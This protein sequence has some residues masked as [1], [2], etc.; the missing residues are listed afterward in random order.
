[1]PDLRIDQSALGGL[2]K[3]LK[4]VDP[5]LQ[6]ELKGELA[7]AAGI[8]ANAAKGKVPSKSGRAAGSIRSGGTA[9]GA[10]VAGG[11]ASVPYYGWL[12]FG[13]RSPISGRPLKVGPWA[14]SGKG[15]LKGRFLYPA[16]AEKRPEVELAVRAAISK[17]IDHLF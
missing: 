17:S 7:K 4:T 10:Y 15:P 3:A 16:I 12:D 8:V 6:K 1:M 9:K 14:G 11:K 5:L 2:M 13:T